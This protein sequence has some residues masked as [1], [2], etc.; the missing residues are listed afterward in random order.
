MD[1]YF[2]ANIKFFFKDFILYFKQVDSKNDR[3][4]CW[5]L[6]SRHCIE[7]ID[8]NASE[9]FNCVLKRI[10]EWKEVLSM[11]LLWVASNFSSFK[12]LKQNEGTIIWDLKGLSLNQGKIITV[13]LLHLS[14][15]SVQL[16]ET[17]STTCK[18]D[19]VLQK[20]G[21]FSFSFFKFVKSDVS[22]FLLHFS[23]VQRASTNT[24][25]TEKDASCYEYNKIATHERAARKV[26]NERIQFMANTGKI[27]R[28][29]RSPEWPW[30]RGKIEVSNVFEYELFMSR[31]RNLLTHNRSS[32][33]VQLF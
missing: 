32:D 26:N 5:I 20:I 2:A 22:Y 16:Q 21:Q 10:Q 11:K 23:N 9:S 6:K 12:T 24:T 7:R 27:Y 13:H 18:Q 33:R 31:N 4:G 15:L 30:F 29:V 1:F 28:R 19:C 17:L 14:F 3:I 8:T 25:A